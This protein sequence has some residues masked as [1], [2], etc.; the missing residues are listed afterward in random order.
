[1]V[2]RAPQSLPLLEDRVLT[3][4]HKPQSYGSQLTRSSSTGTI[5]FFPIE[6]EANVNKRRAAVGLEPLED[7][8]KRFRL[9][10]KLPV[11]QGE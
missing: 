2:K 10:Y 5:E 1:M 8:A 11:S 9:D 6:D 7:Y 4:Q 3:K